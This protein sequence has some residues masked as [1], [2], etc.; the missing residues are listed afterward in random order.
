MKVRKDFLLAIL[1]LF[2]LPIVGYLILSRGETDRMKVSASLQPKDSISLDFVISY[3]TTSGA[4]RTDLLTDMP[5]VL[6]VIATEEDVFDLSH[7]EHIIY[8]IDDRSDLAFLMYED[9]IEHSEKG[10]V[11]GY[12]YVNDEDDLSSYGDVLLVD[13]FNHILKIYEKDDPELYKKILEDISFA[14]PMVDYQIAKMEEN[15]KQPE[16]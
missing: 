16:E 5:Y 7:L 8:I 14:F 13:V 9:P 12:Q 3:L 10:R 6:K 11:M 2:V 15:A 1:V 4:S